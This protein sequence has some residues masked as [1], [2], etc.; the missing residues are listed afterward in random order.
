[1]KKAI[2]PG[3]FDPITNGH[4]D[5]IT[6]LSQIFDHVTVLV[7]HSLKKNYLFS[8]EQRVELCKKSVEGI[9]N[10]SVD[11]FEGLTVDYAK[12]QGANIIVRGIRAVS[13]FEHE[14]A[15]ANV[16]K[17][18]APNIETLIILSKPEYNFV[19]SRLVK[20]VA[21]NK[22]DLS[23]LVPAIVEEAL[24]GKFH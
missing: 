16:N 9:Q 6:R 12:K 1:M 10:V 2:Y 20:E 3:S 17:C 14:T 21:F 19:A 24:K 15:I 18:L 13:D 23:L 5:I 8:A 11:V 22:G 4:I 7:A